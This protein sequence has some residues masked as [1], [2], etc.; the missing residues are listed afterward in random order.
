MSTMRTSNPALK[1]NVFRRAGAAPYVRVA[2]S[3]VMTVQGTITKSLVLTVLAM[4]TAVLPWWLVMNGAAAPAAILVIGGAIAGLVVAIVLAFKPL[5]AP[6]LAPGYAIF[7]GLF[8]GGISAWYQSAYH[9]IVLQAA[10]LTLLTLF[11]MLTAY[12]TGLIRVTN[13]L[14]LAI[15][16][17]TAAIAL[18]YVA[19][20]VLRLFGTT[21]P[22][23]HDSGPIGIAFSLLVVGVASFNLVLD[24]DF[25]EG[26]AGRAPKAME[27]YGAFALL[28]TIVWLYIEFLRLLRK[29]RR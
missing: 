7:E 10:G 27:W 2:A 25:I 15:V 19:T 20:M 5:W 29:M 22:Y 21:I 6:V 18:I 14:R 26:A 13:K 4:A 16:A 1:E 11:A 9:G 12:K 3:D 8:L 23:I 24:F 17:A 28:V